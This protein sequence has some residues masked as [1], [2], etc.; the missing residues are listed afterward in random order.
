M[1]EAAPQPE[2]YEGPIAAAGDGD[3]DGCSC[4]DDR[5]GDPF[6]PVPD[7]DIDDLHVG[8]VA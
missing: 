2:D 3:E 4:G 7:G 5:H 1:A 8:N 6:L